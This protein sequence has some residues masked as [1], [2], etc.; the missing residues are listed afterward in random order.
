[1][2]HDNLSCSNANCDDESQHGV[3]NSSTVTL[4]NRAFALTCHIVI[5]MMMIMMMVVMMMMM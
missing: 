5:E 1:M 3:R 4:F 2:F